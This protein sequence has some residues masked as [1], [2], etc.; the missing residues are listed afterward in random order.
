MFTLVYYYKNHTKMDS[1]LMFVEKAE[2]F[3]RIEPYL[4]F[5]N[6]HQ[7]ERHGAD[8]QGR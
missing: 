1:D 3:A 2:I 6:V 7:L 5:L 4:T 8:I